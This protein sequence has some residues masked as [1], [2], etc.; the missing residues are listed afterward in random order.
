MSPPI[1]NTCAKAVLIIPQAEVGTAMAAKDFKAMAARA[2]QLE[3]AEESKVSLPPLCPHNIPFPQ[4]L[5]S[6]IAWWESHA[7]P[8]IVRLIREGVDWHGEAPQALPIFPCHRQDAD[9]AVCRCV[10]Q[11]YL[12]CGAVTAIGSLQQAL[13]S[14]RY[15]V[16]WT[17]LSKW[18]G[19]N[20]KHRL[21]S[22]CRV[23]NSFLRPPHFKLD[24]WGQI[25]PFVRKGMWAAKIDLRHAYFHLPL[26]DGMKRYLRFNVGDTV[27]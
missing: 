17:V 14:T 4:R 6:R 13:P 10:L 5:K 22:D 8:E 3:R 19:D 11:D 1:R 24:H 7:P 27:F 26:G 16:P 2:P 20:A 12:E 9:V 25:F 18:E 21:I 15:L 23:L